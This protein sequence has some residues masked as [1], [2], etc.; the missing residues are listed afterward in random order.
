M[1]DSEKLMGN[2]IGIFETSTLP[3]MT[4]FE[5]NQY[6]LIRTIYYALK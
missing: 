6:P 4:G 2:F 3:I 1:I 5:G